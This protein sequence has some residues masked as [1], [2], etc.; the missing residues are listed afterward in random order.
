MKDFPARLARL[1]QDYGLLD[2]DE[3]RIRQIARVGL[4]CE[5]CNSPDGATLRYPDAVALCDRCNTQDLA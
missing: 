4:P 5:L 2:E 3:T 1:M